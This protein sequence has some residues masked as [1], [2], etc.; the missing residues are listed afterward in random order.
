MRRGHLDPD[1]R[2]ALSCPPPAR[3][4]SC[5]CVTDWHSTCIAQRVNISRRNNR[6][7]EKGSRAATAGVVD[8]AVD[9]AAVHILRVPSDL[10]FTADAIEKFKTTGKTATP[11]CLPCRLQ[12]RV[13][14]GRRPPARFGEH[15]LCLR[16]GHRRW[17][18]RRSSSHCLKMLRTTS[19]TYAW[20]NV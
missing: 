8:D 5:P 1:A 4:F 16:S 9:A 18:N 20:A 13:N 12:K 3:L 19:Q 7:A 11:A 6:V 10:F 17:Q 14:R 15:Q 2:A